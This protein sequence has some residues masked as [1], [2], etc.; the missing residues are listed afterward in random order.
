VIVQ[1]NGFEDATCACAERLDA[2]KSGAA[3]DRPHRSAY[4]P[5]ASPPPHNKRSTTLPASPY[6]RLMRVGAVES[7]QE[8][9]ACY[10]GFAAVADDEPIM[11]PENLQRD[12]G[13]FAREVMRL[14]RAYLAL[15][16]LCDAIPD[17]AEREE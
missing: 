10:V 16:E 3:V 17:A 11:I 7:L 14:A 6:E 4:I 1:P 2:G 8:K 15:Q 9:A 12:L 5:G 13:K